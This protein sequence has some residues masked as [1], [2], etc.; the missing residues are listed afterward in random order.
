MAHRA[1]AAVR[2]L[3]LMG[4]LVGLPACG[5]SSPT[6]TAG[7]VPANNARNDAD[8]T[9]LQ[10]RIPKDRLAEVRS[11][12]SSLER[13]IIDDG[14]IS[15]AE[16]EAATFSAIRCFT[17]RGFTII[18][19]DGPESGAQS[20]GPRL[21]RRGRYSYSPVSPAGFDAARFGAV[22]ADCKT[23]YATVEFLWATITSP[24]AQEVNEARQ[25]LARC[26]RESGIEV[27]ENASGLDLMT[28]AFPPDGR[29]EPGK[30]RP[31]FYSLCARQ[32]A[33]EYDLPGFL[34]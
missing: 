30:R 7:G 9:K 25:S 17:E 11:A 13:P 27:P 2:L 24:T 34:G 3:A 28:I 5:R 10:Y 15:F 32:V 33:E 4:L 8:V 12:A 21:T 31:E 6:D 16:Y 29:P 23:P 26:L 18:P 19:G 20:A 14:V 1:T 22:I